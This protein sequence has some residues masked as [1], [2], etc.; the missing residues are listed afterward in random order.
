MKTDALV[1]FM[2][3]TTGHRLKPIRLLSLSGRRW[4]NNGLLIPIIAIERGCIKA[5]AV[6]LETSI[7]GVFA[8][9][10]AVSG[11]A[12][13]IQAVAAGKRAAESIARYLNGEDMRADRF[14]ASIKPLPQELLPATKGKEKIQTRRARCFGCR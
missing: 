14:E 2:M 12:S 8:G 1:P 9:G 4:K 10:D 3:I 13:V 6:T 11:P 5:D 7:K